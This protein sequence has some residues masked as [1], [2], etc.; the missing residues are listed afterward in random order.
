[1]TRDEVYRD[2][3]ERRTQRL[4][5]ADEA[6]TVDTAAGSQETTD[7]TASDVPCALAADAIAEAA[8]LESTAG[9][10]TTVSATP[11]PDGHDRGVEPEAVVEQ[12]TGIEAFIAATG[13]LALT[14]PV[15]PGKLE[16][17]LHTLMTRL[18]GADAVRRN[19]VRMMAVAH[20]K[21]VK[22]VGAAQMVDAALA[23]SIAEEPKPVSLVR[24]DDVP[25]LDPVNGVA[26]LEALTAMI[27]RYLVLADVAC[28]AIAL[29][30][31]HTYLMDI[32][33]VSPFLTLVSPTKRCGK[34]TALLLIGALTRRSLVVS[35][36]TPAV[37]FR[38]IDSV[39]PTL[40]AD[41]ADTWLL[42]ERSELRGIYNSGYTK[43]T[44]VVGRCVGDNH[45]VQLFS[46][47]APKVLAM[48]GGPKMPPDTIK[49]RSILIELQRKSRREAVERLRLDRIEADAE[50]LRQSVRRWVSDHERALRW[51]DPEMPAAL[52]DRAQDN[53]RQLL[54][55]A[56]RVGGTWPKLARE[57]AIALAGTVEDTDIQVVLLNDIRQVF[58]D[59][60]TC[61]I[62]STELAKRLAEL[63]GRPWATW[64][65]DKPITPTAVAT[66]LAGFK[67]VPTANAARTARGYYRE[68][69]ADAWS[70]YPPL[71]VSSRPIANET[72][73]DSIPTDRPDAVPADG[74]AFVRSPIDIGRTDGW[75]V[76]NGDEAASADTGVLPQDRGQEAMPLTSGDQTIANV[77]RGDRDWIKL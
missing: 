9:V 25:S 8:P 37:L 54:A 71:E 44:A 20:L 46:T 11:L 17:A 27:R 15:D 45:E 40:L 64:R 59:V 63:E 69:F 2:L 29:W 19:V 47:W 32:W 75:T 3:V 33:S 58:D 12:Q 42:D 49:D 30:I 60:N 57:A 13:L 1:M 67:I 52:D 10:D 24:D 16:D 77:N 72:G 18:R 34:T 28:R 38:V 6:I 4:Q 50:L 31:V 74:S 39:Q 65:R 26:L 68:R 61:F 5:L 36:L 73:H 51:S 23:C 41:E 62:G 22:V 56:D 43:R 70:R 48:I 66:M 14:D 35:N 76:G 21:N 7:T 53:W 55:I